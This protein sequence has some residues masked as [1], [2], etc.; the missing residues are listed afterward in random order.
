MKSHGQRI[1]SLAFAMVAISAVAWWAIA[2]P[3]P[4]T[5]AIPK[6][7][8]TGEGPR[9]ATDDW[10]GKTLGD[11][12]L[13]SGGGPGGGTG[14]GGSP[15]GPSGGDTFQ[16]QV[17]RW[18]A[19]YQQQNGP[20]SESEIGAARRVAERFVQLRW[21]GQLVR[22]EI[23]ETARGYAAAADDRSREE[24][25]A[26]LKRLLGE[27][28]D[29]R[30]EYRAASVAQLEARVRKLREKL[31]RRKE[32]RETLI[33]NRLEQLLGDLEGLGWGDDTEIDA[34]PFASDAASNKPNSWGQFLTKEGVVIPG[35]GPFGYPGSEDLG[36]AAGFSADDS[37][38]KK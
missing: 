27:Q 19:I 20:L 9:A 24:S 6:A 22:R 35:G 5:G 3:P 17:E 38:A 34:D 11:D 16:E 1:F 10:R 31:D 4:D 30:H 36:N 26:K 21:R 25:G 15:G 8:P 18:V 7:E 33:K 23:E 32:L 12:S 29:L 2:Q 14:P 13:Y 28:F 37:P